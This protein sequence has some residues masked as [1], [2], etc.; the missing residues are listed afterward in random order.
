MKSTIIRPLIT[1][2]SLKD[3]KTGYYTFLVDMK[4]RKDEIA[5]EVKK[6]FNV[7]VESVLTSKIRRSRNIA[8]RYGRTSKTDLYKKARVKIG[9]DQK[10][11]VFEEVLKG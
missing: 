2:K 6:L 11:E 4:A 7:D 10:I 3:A 9:K 8:N 1:E 5:G